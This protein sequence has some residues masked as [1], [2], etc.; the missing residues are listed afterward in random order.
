[1]KRLLPAWTK[2][3]QIDFYLLAALLLLI[4][5]GLLVLYSASGENMD[6]VIRQGVRLGVGFVGMLVISQ[7]L[8][9][10]PH[11]EVPAIDYVM[12]GDAELREVQGA[13]IEAERQDDGQRLAL[14]HGRFDAIDG[15]AARSRAGQLLHGLGFSSAD[16]ERPVSAFSGG[17][18]MRLNLAQALMC[19]SDLLL[20]DEP[21]NHL[22]LDAV[23]WLEGWLRAYPG[24]LL[25]ISHDRD[26]IDGCCEAVLHIEGH[27]LEA[28]RGGYSDFERQRALRIAEAHRSGGDQGIVA[29]RVSDAPK[30]RGY[31]PYST[32]AMNWHTDGYYNPPGLYDDGEPVQLLDRPF[33]YTDAI[34]DRAVALVDEAPGPGPLALVTSVAAAA[35]ARIASG[36]VTSSSTGTTRPCS[37]TCSCRRRPT[38]SL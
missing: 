30:Q 18:R 37:T 27:R 1:M 38:V 4:S 16:E 36:S 3:P 11:S 34:S 33:Y 8:Q 25:L 32:R 10:M 7:V 15:Y 22:E 13:L 6:V 9:E 31:I 2:W 26:F 12:D 29:L 19:R 28:Y 21:T 20:L 35:A 5:L 14:Q 23:I 24:T 17:W